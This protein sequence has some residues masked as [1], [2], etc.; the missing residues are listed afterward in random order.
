MTIE[1]LHIGQVV[2]FQ[3]TGKVVAIDA[4]SYGAPH[5]RLEYRYQD[6]LTQKEKKSSVLVEVCLLSVPTLTP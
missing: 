2:E 5:A 1:E 3:I 4:D 6:P